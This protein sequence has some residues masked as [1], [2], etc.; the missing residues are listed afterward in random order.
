MLVTP[1]RRVKGEFAFLLMGA[2]LVTLRRFLV[3]P[4]EKSIHVPRAGNHRIGKNLCQWPAGAERG[5]I[6]GWRT[7]IS[8]RFWAQW[9]R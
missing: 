9:G 2:G 8:S 3:I 5:L 1:F 6:Y 7:V 4:P